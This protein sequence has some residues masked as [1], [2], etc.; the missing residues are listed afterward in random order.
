M[1]GSEPGDAVR[2]VNAL[3][4]QLDALK[5]RPNV[6][7][8]LIRAPA[9][10][11][12]PVF[13]AMVLASCALLALLNAPKPSPNMLGCPSLT[14]KDCL[15]TPY[16]TDT[17]HAVKAELVL[18]DALQHR[19]HVRVRLGGASLSKGA[20]H[21]LGTL[22]RPQTSPAARVMSHAQSFV[23]HLLRGS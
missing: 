5:R 18:L 23:Q 8:R 2:V 6:L 1:S 22:S 3:L 13:W 7:V 14:A 12:S 16:S 11:L 4:T 19:S 20:H 15:I 10:S 17:L 9:I 21:E